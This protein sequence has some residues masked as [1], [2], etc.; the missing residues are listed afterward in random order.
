MPQLVATSP[1]PLLIFSCC[2]NKL[3][4]FYILITTSTHNCQP[5]KFRNPDPYILQL[6]YCFKRVIATYPYQIPRM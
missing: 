5:P 3:M 2:F 6:R 1:I 4:S